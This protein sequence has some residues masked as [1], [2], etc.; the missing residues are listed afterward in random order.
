MLFSLLGSTAGVSDV[1]KTSVQQPRSAEPLPFPFVNPRSR[2][3]CGKLREAS[4]WESGVRNPGPEGRRQ[5]SAQP[6]RAGSLGRP[7]SAGGAAPHSSFCHL[8]LHRISYFTALTG[9]T[10]VVLLKENRMQLLE[11]AA[12]DRKSGEAEGS[13]V[14][15]TLRGKGTGGLVSIWRARPWLGTGLQ[16][17]AEWRPREWADTPRMYPWRLRA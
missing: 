5:K 16:A 15:R 6:G 14:P 10:Y 12:L 9:A 7:S 17:E 4:P 1:I 2:L 3:A 8:E 13:A 11:A